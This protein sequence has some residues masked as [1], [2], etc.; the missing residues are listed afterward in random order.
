VRE[1]LPIAAAVG[2]HLGRTTAYHTGHGACAG[3][4]TLLSEHSNTVCGP[5]PPRSDQ[6]VRIHSLDIQVRPAAEAPDRDRSPKWQRRP[7]QRRRE[8]LDSA[9]WVFG[10][11]GYQR[12]TLADVAERAGVSPGTVS[13][14]FGSKG[15]LFQEVIAQ[16]FMGFVVQEEALLA[17]SAGPVRPLLH[18]L[19][20]RMWDHAWTPGILELMQVVQ[21]EAAEFPES[22]RLLCRQL[23]ERWRSL[24]GRI[25]ESGAGTGEFRALDPE[26]AARAMSYTLFGVAQKVSTFSRFDPSMPDREVMWQTVLEMID[27]FLLAEL[28][29]EEPTAALREGTQSD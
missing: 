8:I 22:G 21:V 23:G 10:R 9:L 11:F 17:S 14:Y 24:V 13:H 3:A 1:P 25:L 6:V 18:Q 19:L 16:H 28:P 4:W 26:P 15:E 2:G 27:R 5:I 7:E 20:R 12:A 29:C